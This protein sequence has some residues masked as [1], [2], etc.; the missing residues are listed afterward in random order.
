[1]KKLIVLFSL[2][3]V[4][5]ERTAPP[6]VVKNKYVL[7]N[8][9]SVIEIDSCEY[10]EGYSLLTHKGNCRYCIIRNKLK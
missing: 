2:A 10:I 8:S 9:Y 3:L 4:S 6:S 1:M 5:C 7:D